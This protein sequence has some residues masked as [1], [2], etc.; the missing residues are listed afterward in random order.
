[1]SDLALRDKILVVTCCFKQEFYQK[2]GVNCMP[3][4][5]KRAAASKKVIKEDAKK[6]KPKTTKK[7]T[8]KKADTKTKTKTT[9]KT[10]V[11]EEVKEE[12]NDKLADDG[13]SRYVFQKKTTPV[14]RAFQ[15]LIESKVKQGKGKLTAEELQAKGHNP[16]GTFARGRKKHPDAGRKKGTPNSFTT[17]VRSSFM[18]AFDQLGGT[19]GLVAWAS[20]CNENLSEFYKILSRL[21]PKDIRVTETNDVAPNYLENVKDGDLDAIIG[22]CM[23]RIK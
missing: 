23:G 15:L 2:K 8:T 9:R 17:K 19:D 12:L 3:V 14:P 5:K 1:M 4:S 18:E 20:G 10:K 16:D 21:T 7:K 11:A 6:A 22:S 13:L